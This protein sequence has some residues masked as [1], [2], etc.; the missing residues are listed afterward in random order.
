MCLNLLTLFDSRA[1][2]SIIPIELFRLRLRLPFCPNLLT[3]LD[4]LN[5][6]LAQLHPIRW[7][8]CALFIYAKVKV[9]TSSGLFLQVFMVSKLK[10][11]SGG[12]CMFPRFYIKFSV[13][14]HLCSKIVVNQNKVVNA[15][16]GYVAITSSTS[17]EEGWALPSIRSPTR[18]LVLKTTRGIVPR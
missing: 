18:P 1:D 2:R 3:L 5:I 7:S 12:V 15:W 16:K 8:L 10:E 17:I 11:E 13:K 9:S 6:C 4:S 14:I